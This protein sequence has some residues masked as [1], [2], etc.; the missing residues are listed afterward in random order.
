MKK[1]IWITW[2]NQR[3]SVELSQA[4][5]V[6]FFLLTSN[7]SRLMRYIILGSKT[8]RLLLAEKPHQVIVQNPSIILAYLVC[9]LKKIMRFR[10]IVDRHSNFKLATLGSSKLIH[11]IFHYFSRYSIKHADLTIVTNDFLKR[12]LEDWGGSG[13]ILQDRFPSLPHASW[14]PLRGRY[15]C[16]FICS[17]SSD[18]EPVLEVIKAAEMLGEET[19]IYIT[20]N[21]RKM[22]EQIENMIPAN[23]SLT[24]YLTEKDFQSLVGSCDVVIALTTLE[25]TL[26]CAA[27]EA[28]SLSKPIVLSNKKELTE[29]FYKGI[30]STENSATHI[31]DAIKKA[32]ARK[33]VL[34]HE[35]IELKAELSVAWDQRFSVLRSRLLD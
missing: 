25:H 1:T 20:G 17:F 16:V 30:V 18:D 8:T 28:V 3:R 7:S 5:G 35:I 6:P 22:G 27:Y 24:G 9:L 14:K 26:L 4:L 11:K 13:Y 10:V 33:E 32:L 31:A 29:Y 21:Y 19:V 2:E 23:V 15:N 12:M 34:G